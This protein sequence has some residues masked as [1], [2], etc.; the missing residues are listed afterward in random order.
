MKRT[1]EG[2]STLLSGL[3]VGSSMLLPGMSG[4]TMAIILG[5]YS[6]LIHAISSLT[7]DRG[8]KRRQSLF[9][10][11]V[12]CLGS[13]GGM[14]LFSKAVLYLTERFGDPML[15]LFSGLILGS[16][17]VLWRQA[18]IRRPTPGCLAGAAL[19]L[20]LV[21]ALRL[22]PDGLFAAG[23]SFSIQGALL[24]FLAGAVV[25]V[26][27]VL[28]GIS[29]SHVLLL[30][31]LY[32]VA[33]SSVSRLYLPFLLPLALGLL[34]GILATTSLLDRAMERRPQLT[35]SLIIGFVMG[36]VAEVFPGFSGGW[37]AVLTGLI[38]L[39][40]GCAAT[41]LLGRLGRAQG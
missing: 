40:A 32:Q 36:S 12:F 1:K 8:A 19:G 9:F 7:R 24:L 39:A 34:G 35:Y 10:L 17:P 5:I 30:L 23:E 27:L 18:G 26:A 16:L 14:L 22:L 13:V 11:L 15:F 31:G 33:L 21:F 3:V 41:L 28:P 2:L 6:R 29:A 20:G 37:E 4:G 25:A 38:C